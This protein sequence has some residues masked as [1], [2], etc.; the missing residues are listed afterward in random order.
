MTARTR[1]LALAAS[2][3]A[4]GG[5]TLAGAASDVPRAS[6]AQPA[7]WNVVALGE[8]RRNGGRR[9][10]GPRLGRALR[11]SAPAG[12]SASKWPSAILRR[13]DLTTR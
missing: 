3:L 2:G 5:M 10:D 4:V 11:A 9:L 12:A 6:A 1:L 8:L 13:T 7:V